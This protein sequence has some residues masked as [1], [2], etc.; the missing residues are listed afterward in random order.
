MAGRPLGR[1]NLRTYLALDEAER[2][3]IKPIESALAVAA[4][5][6]KIVALSI[7]SFNRLQDNES[8][9]KQNSALQH[10]SNATKALSEK[11]AIYLKL[12]SIIYPTVSAVNVSQV[13]DKCDS[14]TD[15]AVDAMKIRQKILQ[16]PIILEYTTLPIGEKN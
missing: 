10:L 12:T 15:K 13:F 16:D 11:A 8:Q 5:L 7:E 1:K 2:L 14:V 9:S 6:D 3:K 4:E